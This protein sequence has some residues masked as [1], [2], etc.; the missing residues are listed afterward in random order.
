MPN[1]VVLYV[2]GFMNKQQLTDIPVVYNQTLYLLVEHIVEE[3]LIYDTPNCAYKTVLTVQLLPLIA[4][5]TTFC[6]A[7]FK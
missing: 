5:I 4:T 7:L 3:C 1:T 6:L 2:L